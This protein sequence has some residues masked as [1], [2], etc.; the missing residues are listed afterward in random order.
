[1]DLE[2]FFYPIAEE[3]NEL[4]KGVPGL[5]VAGSTTPQVLTAAVLTFT[6]GQPSGDKLAQFKGINSYT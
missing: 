1:M 5:M 4:A 6:T 2:S 3:L